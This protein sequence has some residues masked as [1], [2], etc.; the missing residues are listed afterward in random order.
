MVT[1][2]I[3]PADETLAVSRHEFNDLHDYQKA[4]G[5]LIEAIDLGSPAMT[6]F[7]NDEAKLIGL[8]INRRATMLWWLHSPATYGYD[9]LA[10]D[11]VLVGQP[12]QHGETQ[13]A[14]AEFVSL[15]MDTSSFKVEVQ[16]AGPGSPWYGNGRR[17][18]DY[19]T[20]ALYA[21]DLSCRWS[22]VTRARVAAA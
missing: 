8:P 2:V 9:V 19:F 1:G 20:A 17:F 14:P 22:Q 6:F 15:L 13:S 16:T 4:V 3:I 10:G 18:E 21:T 7:A 11:A 5:G 12:D